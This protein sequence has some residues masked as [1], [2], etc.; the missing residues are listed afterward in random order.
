MNLK[1]LCIL[2]NFIIFSEEK[3]CRVAIIHFQTLWAKYFTKL[4]YFSGLQSIL[5]LFLAQNRFYVTFLFRETNLNM[6]IHRFESIVMDSADCEGISRNPQNRFR[7]LSYRI[8]IC[9]NG[10]KSVYVFIEIIGE[11]LIHKTNFMLEFET[12]QTTIWKNRLIL[13]NILFIGNVEQ[14]VGNLL[15][16]TSSQ[17]PPMCQPAAQVSQQLLPLH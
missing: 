16:K 12:K 7:N 3:L 5:S 8:Q 17:V 6:E 14:Q 15:K 2:L 10:V 9:H 11:N 4:T 13:W 1:K